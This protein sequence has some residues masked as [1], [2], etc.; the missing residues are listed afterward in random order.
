[1][2]SKWKVWN[3]HINHSQP[4]ESPELQIEILT[5]LVGYDE[6]KFADRSFIREVFPSFPRSPY[7]SSLP[8]EAHKGEAVATKDSAQSQA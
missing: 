1:M 8:A 7:P 3:G 5:R 4:A 6:E 2:S